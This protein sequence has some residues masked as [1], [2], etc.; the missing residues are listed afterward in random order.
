M[1]N[2]TVTNDFTNGTLADATE[3]NQN[4]TDIE[5]EVNRI[6]AINAAGGL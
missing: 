1:A 4:F 3:V 6:R 5:K 2:F